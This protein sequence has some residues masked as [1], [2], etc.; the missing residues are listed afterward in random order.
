MLSVSWFRKRYEAR[1]SFLKSVLQVEKALERYKK[2]YGKEPPRIE[3]LITMGLLREIPIDPSGGTL[4]LDS[5]GRV[6]STS[7]FPLSVRQQD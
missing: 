6:R 1:L 3:D 2:K 7:E 4:Y 5:N